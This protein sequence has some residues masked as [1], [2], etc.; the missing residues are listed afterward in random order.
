[1]KEKI[2]INPELKLPSNEALYFKSL[3]EMLSFY[4]WVSENESVEFLNRGS[5]S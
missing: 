4:K 5:Q 3:E 1:M 2:E